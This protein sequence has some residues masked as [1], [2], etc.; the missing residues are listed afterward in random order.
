MSSIEIDFRRAPKGISLSLDHAGDA[1][2]N[3][4]DVKLSELIERIGV[5]EV[6]DCIGKTRAVEYFEIVEDAT[7]A[8]P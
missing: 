2:L 3:L 5:E 7:G 8:Q 4:G 6:L 1:I